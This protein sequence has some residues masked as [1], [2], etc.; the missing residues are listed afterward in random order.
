MILHRHYFRTYL[1]KEVC[2]Q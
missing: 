2:K 1:K